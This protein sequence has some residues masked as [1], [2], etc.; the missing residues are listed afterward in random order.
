MDEKSLLAPG[1]HDF[2]LDEIGNQF[3]N[4]FP[5]SSTRKTLLDGLESFVEQLQKVGVPIELWIDGSFTTEKENPNDIDMVLAGSCCSRN[6][7]PTPIN[8]RVRLVVVRPRSSS[9]L[10]S[11]A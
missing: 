4:G 9:H 3:L 11:D 8:S 2:D 5:N 6:C 1:M 7:L 10:S